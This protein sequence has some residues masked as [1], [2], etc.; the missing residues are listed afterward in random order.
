[1]LWIT[2]AF[3]HTLALSAYSW[4]VPGRRLGLT[5]SELSP[6]ANVNATLAT[7]T[8]L[9]S[10]TLGRKPSGLRRTRSLVSPEPGVANPTNLS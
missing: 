1:M 5:N 9:S 10:R 3:L 6:H 4:P 2:A 7:T 8:S